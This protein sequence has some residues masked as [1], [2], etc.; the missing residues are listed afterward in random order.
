MSVG[1]AMGVCIPPTPKK[2]VLSERPGCGRS[3]RTLYSPIIGGQ[4]G[5][6]A[7]AN[8]ENLTLSISVDNVRV[9]TANLNRQSR[10]DVPKER[11]ERGLQRE[12]PLLGGGGHGGPRFI[13]AAIGRDEARPSRGRGTRGGEVKTHPNLRLPLSRWDGFSPEFI[14]RRKKPDQIAEQ[15]MIY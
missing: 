1:R 11:L 12:L 7:H 9:N 13:V 5:L 14:V 4:R 15:V 10:Q 2:N 8:P 3:L 6:T